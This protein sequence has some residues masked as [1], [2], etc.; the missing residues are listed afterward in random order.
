MDLY[1]EK[2]NVVAGR[3]LRIMGV[4]GALAFIGVGIMFYVKGTGNSGE[5]LVVSLVLGVIA[6]VSELIV[7]TILGLYVVQIVR[8]TR[9]EIVSMPLLAKWFSGLAWRIPIQ[10]INEASVVEYA[11]VAEKLEREGAGPGA[12]VTYFQ[13]KGKKVD[14]SFLN[15]A[16]VDGDG[17][18]LRVR[19]PRGEKQ[20]AMLVLNDRTSLFLGLNNPA[21]AVDAIRQA[22]GRVS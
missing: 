2:S 5:R 6:P 7:T 21:E 11:Q 20:G 22:R 12:R 8:V 10:S 17:I 3:I 14:K 18:P 16:M 4:V 15:A 1:E 19:R 13:E 9:D